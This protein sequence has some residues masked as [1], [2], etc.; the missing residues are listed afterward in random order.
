M[1]S[2][3]HFQCGTR[4]YPNLGRAVGRR[5]V[6]QALRELLYILCRGGPRQVLDIYLDNSIIYTASNV[7]RDAGE[8]RYHV[9]FV[10]LPPEGCEVHGVL[11]RWMKRSTLELLARDKDLLL[12]QSTAAALGGAALSPGVEETTA[13]SCRGYQESKQG[14]QSWWG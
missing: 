13:E 14:W 1:D 7:T 6:L 4:S 2:G 11:Q 3:A 5:L 10:T 8:Y 12:S 9:G